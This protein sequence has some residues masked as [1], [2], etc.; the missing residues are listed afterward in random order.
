M[1]TMLRGVIPALVTTLDSNERFAARPME[2]LLERVYSAGSDG[3]YVCG[4][5]GEGLLLGKEDRKQAAVAAVRNSPRGKQVVVH[6]GAASTADAV[7]LTQHAARA[8]AHAVSS[9]P[10]SNAF[11]FPEVR[12]YYEAIAAAADLPVLVYYF[13]E[14]SRSVSTL[15]E[16]NCLCSI[17]NVAGLKFTDFDFYRLSLIA[18]A[19]HVIFS[20]RDEAFAC[21]VLMGATGGIGS[22]YN[23]IPE[24]FVQVWRAGLAGD[25]ATARLVQDRINDLIRVVL[26]FPMLPAIKTL[27]VV[28][29]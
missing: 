22:F 21:G 7:E 13:P 10:P 1:S 20:G 25:F 8:G 2:Q 23:L 18:R 26:R 17:P 12:N 24:M 15:D 5:T 9:L 28:W 3:V 19:G 29:H 16:I 4:Q 14:F 27:D 11:T 6:V